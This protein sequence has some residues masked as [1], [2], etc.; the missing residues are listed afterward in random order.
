MKG[1]SPI[2]EKSLSCRNESRSATKDEDFQSKVLKSEVKLFF[3]V[4][5]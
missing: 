3:G 4:R 1:L 2:E 5:D